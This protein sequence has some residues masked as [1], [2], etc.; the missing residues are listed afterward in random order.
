LSHERVQ[1]LH[2]QVTALESH[3]SEILR[4]EAMLA[5]ARREAISAAETLR[6]TAGGP[7][8]ALVPVG[9]GI[10]LGAR[11]EDPGRVAIDV[12]AGAV[13]EKSRAAAI[14]HV[15][16]QIKSL[17]VALG[18]VAEQK[19]QVAAQVQQG[20]QELESLVRAEMAAP[21]KNV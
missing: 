17:E 20:R 10:F 3:Y 5:T 15:E 16:A 14:D 13:L 11:V 2:D 4:Q 1:Q 12:G 6:E 18:N 9:S 21:G 8:E 7:L 19:R